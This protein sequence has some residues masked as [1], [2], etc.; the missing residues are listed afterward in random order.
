MVSVQV[1]ETIRCTP[2]ELLEF[3]MDIERYAEV[4]RK[5]QPIRWSRRE[6]N[7]LEFACRPK[8][9]GLRQPTVVQQVRLTP[10]ERIDITLSPRPHNRLAHAMA[11][12]DAH[13]EATATEGGTRVVRTLNF[14]FTPAVRWLLEPLL[15]RRL[16]AEVRDEISLAKRHLEGRGERDR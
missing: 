8:L 5:I 13:F 1:A 4:D 2:D 6:G 15:R 9:A 7:L 11:S 3:V 12:F 14:R 16:P 10:G